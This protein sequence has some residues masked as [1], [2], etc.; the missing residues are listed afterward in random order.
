M[1]RI[2][3]A[4]ITDRHADPEPYLF[5]TADDAITFA[6]AEARVNAR[7]LAG[8]E[9][10]EYADDGQIER[11]DLDAAD[12]E[13]LYYTAYSNEGDCAWVVAKDLPH[14]VAILST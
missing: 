10:G 3:V 5:E 9:A 4:M 14:V 11:V 6:R 13:W 1:S 2:Y 7:D 8:Y 12:G